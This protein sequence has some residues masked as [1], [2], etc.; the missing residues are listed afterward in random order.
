MKILCGILLLILCVVTLPSHAGNR[1]NVTVAGGVMK[2]KGV[3]LAEACTVETS[4]QNLYVQMGSVSTNSFKYAGE[5][6]NPVRF[7]IHLRDCKE[8]VSKNVGIEFIGVADGKDPQV[9]SVGE[10]NGIASGVG[11]SI[12]DNENHLVPINQVI[13]KWYPLSNGPVT[14]SFVAKYRATGHEVVGGKASSEA[15]FKLTYQ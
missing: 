1:W 8:N 5:D 3:L 10:G 14:L 6:V 11:I 13:D 12:F 2:F 9:L 15:Q 4:D 7:E